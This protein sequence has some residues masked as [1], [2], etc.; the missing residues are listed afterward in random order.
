M[1]AWQGL[2]P[3]T[4]CSRGKSS[5]PHLSGPS[6]T[7]SADLSSVVAERSLGASRS[8]QAVGEVLPLLTSRVTRELFSP[9]TRSTSRTGS[10]CRQLMRTRIASDHPKLPRTAGSGV[11]QQDG[12]SGHR[13]GS[14]KLAGVD[15]EPNPA[16]KCPSA[17]TSSRPLVILIRRPTPGR[18]S[19]HTVSARGVAPVRRRSQSQP[20]PSAAA[21]PWI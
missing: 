15:G 16:T 12:A 17:Q 9:G 7:H 3:K 14:R 13:A 4:T 21:M 10:R 5:G 20:C 19:S 6:A 8:A 18:L 11:P 2:V 1:N